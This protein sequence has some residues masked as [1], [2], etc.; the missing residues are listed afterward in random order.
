METPAFYSILFA[1]FPAVFGFS[2]GVNTPL[3]ILCSLIIL[4]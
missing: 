1:L 2:N 4:N 3:L